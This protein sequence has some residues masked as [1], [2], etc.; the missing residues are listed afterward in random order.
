MGSLGPETAQR[1]SPSFQAKNARLDHD[2]LIIGAGLSGIYATYRMRQLGLRSLVLEAAPSVGGTWFWNRYPGARFDSESYSYNFFFSPELLAEWRWSEHFAPQPE[3]LRYCEFV[4][5]KFDL[6]R[7]MQFDTRV[8]SACWREG[9]TAAGGGGGDDD[10]VKGGYWVL[11]DEAGKTYT[12]RY[13]ITAMGILNAFTLPNIPGVHDF[14]GQ[15][16]HTA[17]WPREPVSLE[18]KRVAVLGTGATGVSA[19]IST[20]I[21]SPRLFRK[22][23]TC[24]GVLSLSVA[25]G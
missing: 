23:R 14:Q 13:L 1:S 7:D 19:H 22:R 24:A 15:A 21:F 6:R 9:E 10:V 17:Q 2:V 5:D 12:A 3:T 16:F 8:R 20:M 18:G 11:T 4:C 25:L